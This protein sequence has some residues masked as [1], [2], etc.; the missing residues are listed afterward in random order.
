MYWSICPHWCFSVPNRLLVLFRSFSVCLDLYRFVVFVPLFLF[1]VMFVSGVCCVRL[2]FV[3]SFRSLSISLFSRWSRSFSLCPVLSRFV[4]LFG[5][6][7]MHSWFDLFFLFWSRSVSFCLV[8]SRHV[9][10]ILDLFC[11]FSFRS[12][13][14]VMYRFSHF[15]SRFHVLSHSFSVC[16]VI[17]RFVLFLLFLPR[18]LSFCPAPFRY[19]PLF[20]VWSHLSG[21]AT[22]FL[23]LSCSSSLRLV[24]SRVVPLFLVLFRYFS[25]CTSCLFLGCVVLILLRSVSLYLVLSCSFSYRLVFLSFCPVLSRFVFFFLL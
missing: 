10:C 2:I 12:F 13:L 1:C 24:P 8:L 3:S 25:S 6:V 20:L 18:S 5:F 17:P 4:F 19:V 11:S 9:P 23:A 14:L 7:P 15:V 21:Y 16:F 22:F